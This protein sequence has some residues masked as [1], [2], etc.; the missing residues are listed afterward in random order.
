MMIRSGHTAEGVIVHHTVSVFVCQKNAAFYLFGAMAKGIKH[1]DG[2]G[3][4][5][6]TRLAAGLRAATGPDD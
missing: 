6:C 5:P 4:I 2:E 3:Q 1:R